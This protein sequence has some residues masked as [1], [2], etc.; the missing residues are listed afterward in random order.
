[1][2]SEIASPYLGFLVGKRPSWFLSGEL[3]ATVQLSSFGEFKIKE[4]FT[5]PCVQRAVGISS[6]MSPE[7]M[8]SRPRAHLFVGPECGNSRPCSTSETLCRHRRVSERMRSTP[9]L[10]HRQKQRWSVGIRTPQLIL[11]SSAS[12]EDVH[13]FGPLVLLMVCH[14]SRGQ[15]PAVVASVD[16]S[17]APGPLP[18]QL[19]HPWP[20]IFILGFCKPGSHRWN[21]AD[22]MP[23][24]RLLYILK[25][26][27]YVWVLSTEICICLSVVV[28]LVVVFPPGL[29]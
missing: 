21:S 11:L 28:V 17:R 18:L 10:D 24:T 29:R 3:S 1:M 23:H 2:K 9:A 26:L 16:P 4:V 6:W 27:M 19:H 7:N 14:V 12:S 20:L 5:V 15:S 22:T 25:R 13:S 8:W